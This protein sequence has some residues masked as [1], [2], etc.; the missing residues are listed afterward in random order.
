MQQHGS[1][2]F[3]RGLPL[4]LGPFGDGVK[5]SNSTFSEHVHVAYQI[6]GNLECRTWSQI[7]F[8]ASPLTLGDQNSHFQ[9]NFMLHIKL[10]GIRNAE[11]GQNILPAD[12]P[13]PLAIRLGSKGQI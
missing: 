5:R 13:H 12:P 1:K 7:F 8:P 10:K 6:K 9:N 3:A 4:P 2:Y 11:H